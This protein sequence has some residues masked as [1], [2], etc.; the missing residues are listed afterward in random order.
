MTGKEQTNTIE[1]PV[2]GFENRAGSLMCDNCGTLLNLMAESRRA[3][4]DLRDYR[5]A[6]GDDAAKAVE[7]SSNERVRGAEYRIGMS[8]QLRVEEASQPVVINPEMLTGDVIMGRRD[9]ITEQVPEVDLDRYAGYRMGVSRRHAILR[10]IGDELKLID[11]GS[12][13]GT[14]LN[15]ERLEA[16]KPTTILEGD[17]MRLGQIIMKVKFMKT[18]QG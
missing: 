4:R 9:P 10:L 12:S 8:V 2:C 5:D 13:N 3:T 7:S 6:L 15:G 1:C 16:R 14:Y 18:Q 17:V 11:L